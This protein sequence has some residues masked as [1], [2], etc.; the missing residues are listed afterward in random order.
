MHK[1]SSPLVAADAQAP[2]VARVQR[3]YGEEFAKGFVMAWLVYLNEVLNLNKPMNETQIELCANSV[4]KEFYYL[5]ISDLSLLFHRIITGQYGEFY[6]SLSIAKLLSFF[7]E[8]EKERTEMV[9]EE[10]DR[11]HAEF[12][13]QESKN[14]TPLDF[15]K[16]QTKKIYRW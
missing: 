5:K 15:F 4:M 6:E 8:Y 12:R 13:Y 16:R 11:Q 1:L 7:R 2:S 3:E 9:L 10:N 14:Q